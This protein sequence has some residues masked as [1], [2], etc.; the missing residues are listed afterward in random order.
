MVG[1]HSLFWEN[2]SLQFIVF[3]NMDNSIEAQSDVCFECKYYPGDD[4]SYCMDWNSCI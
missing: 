2:L 1:Q 3:D 4:D